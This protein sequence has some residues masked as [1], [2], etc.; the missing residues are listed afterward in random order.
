MIVDHIFIDA[1]FSTVNAHEGEMIDIAAIRTDG[2]GNPL[3][4]AV[5]G[6]RIQPSKAVPSDSYKYNGYN[7]SDWE[8][9]LP[10]EAAIASLRSIL[11]SKKYDEQYAVIAFDAARF[12]HGMR[13]SLFP[14][15]NWVDMSGVSWPLLQGD[16]VTDR[17]LGALSRFYK[18][19]LDLDLSSAEGNVATLGA[20][21]WEMMR[22][23]Q[24]ALKGETMIQEVIGGT[25]FDTVRRFLKI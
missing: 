6:A 15:R 13:S 16:M 19:S 4:G 12:T 20:V 22:R 9:A 11:L 8:E 24:S 3:P 25:K 18:V 2:R 7:A 1:R 14:K 17:T 21:Y 5:F 10:R 23:L